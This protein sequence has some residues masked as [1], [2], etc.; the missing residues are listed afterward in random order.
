MPVLVWSDRDG[1]LASSI[2]TGRRVSLS[3]EEFR[4]EA[5]D[6]DRALDALLDMAWH[7][8]KVITRHENDKLQLNSFEQAWTLGR[9]VFVSGILN[10]DALQGEERSLLWQALT[11]KAWYG[12]RHDA[13]REPHW[14]ALIPAR[15]KR[16]RSHAAESTAYRFLDIGYW[17]REQQLHNAGEV[18]GWYASN[19]EDIYKRPSLRSFELRQEILHWLQRQSPEV[20][21][22]LAKPKV[23]GHLRFSIVSKA[24]LARFP[25]RGPGSALLPQH[26]PPDELRAIVTATLDAARDEHFTAGK[27]R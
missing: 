4:P 17:L 15:A 13:S 3:A 24:L 23:K 1:A 10:H 8:L 19:A 16:W 12:V 6:L 22:E 11:P 9:A 21:A 7:A 18:F 27:L 25:H 2:R 14:K 5:E 20:R 26:Y